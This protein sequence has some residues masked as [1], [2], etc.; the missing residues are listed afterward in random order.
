MVM[1]AVRA[2]RPPRLYVAADGPRD[3]PGEAVRCEEA[4]RIATTVDWDCDVRTLFRDSNL[5]CREAVSSAI[6][7]FFQHELQGIILE[8]DCLPS[9]DF[10][11]FCSELLDRYREDARIMAIC[12]SSY[13]AP[14]K[15]YAPSYYFSYYADIWGWASWRRAWQCYER[16]MSRWPDARERRDLEYIWGGRVWHE[17]YWT[18]RFDSTWAGY[19]DTWDYQWNFAV[20]QQ[21]GLACYPVRN[22]IS[23]LGYRPDAT[24]TIAERAENGRNPIANLPRQSL[25]FPLVHPARVERSPDL[26]RAIEST[27]LGL[28]PPAHKLTRRVKNTLRKLISDTILGSIDYYCK[29]QLK[30][31]WGGP[32]NG[33]STRQALFRAIITNIEPKALIETGTYLGTTTEFM[34]MTGMPVFTIEADSRRFGYARARLWRHRSVTLL[35]SGSRTG[36]RQL[37]A[38][39]LRQTIR[40]VLF[41]YSGAHWNDDLPLIEELDT[42]FSHCPA[43]VVMIDGFQVPFDVG[44]E[45]DDYG[46]GKALVAGYIAPVVSAQG[47]QAFYPS[48]P[49][50]KESGARRGCVVLAKHPDLIATLSSLP[51]LCWDDG[52]SAERYRHSTM[53]LN[54]RDP[55]GIN[56]G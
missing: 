43:A 21:R 4:R 37:F 6:T 52:S 24:H 54:S 29:P 47:L 14:G 25:R 46:P 22:L 17:A 51:L 33:Q 30:T 19:I 50:A 11:R 49:S 10:F 55:H 13:A 44:Y 32:F 35:N 41:F 26:D 15:S 45:Y 28:R 8:D 16:D 23:N 18:N 7:W 9:S 1:E 5:G 38:S 56:P 53:R 48:T 2:A 36:L 27:R 42:V 3:R 12:G 34:A 20:M 40:D 31:A 39:S